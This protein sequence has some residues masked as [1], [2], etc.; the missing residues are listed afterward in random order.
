MNQAELY[1]CQIF[2]IWLAGRQGAA[3]DRS[4][5]VSIGIIYTKYWRQCKESDESKHL[6]RFIRATPDLSYTPSLL[7]KLSEKI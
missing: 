1:M 2:P 3:F 5:A 7:V 6:S 4:S